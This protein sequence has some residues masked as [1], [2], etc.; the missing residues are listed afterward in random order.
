[1]TIQHQAALVILLS[2]TLTAAAQT[3]APP[4]KDDLFAGT[5]K[6]AQGASSV[7]QIDM[8]PDSLGKV[9]GKDSTKARRT[10]LSVVHT[11]E[12]DKPGMYKIEDVNAF[13]KKLE[14]GDWHCSVHM[15]Q[16]KT[17]Q[18]TDI[19]NKRRTDELT[20][21]A[22]ITV[23]PKSLT[24]IHTI[25][26]EGNWHGSEV[27]LPSQMRLFGPEMQA[28][29]AVA[30]AEMQAE[31]A[32]MRPQMEGLAIEMKNFKGPDPEQMRH[33]QEDIQKSFGGSKKDAV[34]TPQPPQP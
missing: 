23:D 6:F 19:C 12:Y 20:E 17:G 10:V 22:I 4:V 1:M 29:M 28:E 30:R 13:R 24:F 2:S 33:M 25:Q 3:S 21:K 5:E 9:E 18:S 8:D 11:Y 32:A 14:T 15:Q 27:F 16:L 34:P 31:M 7:T 26:H